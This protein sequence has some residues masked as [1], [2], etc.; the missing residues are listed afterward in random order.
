VETCQAAGIRPVMITGDH[1]LTARHI[2]SQLGIA[3]DERFLTG[4]ELDHLSTADLEKVIDEVSVYARVSPEHKLNLI[5]V[6]QNR[7]HIVAMTGD[8]VNDAPAL[9]KADIGVAMG[10]TGTD[11]TKEAADMV[12]QDDNF[13]TI[14]A[15]VE[16]GR[17][18]Y[19]NIRKFIKYL[20]SCNSGEIWAM[21]LAPLFGMPLPLLPLQILWMNLVTDGLPALALGVEPGERDT[22]RR[23]P[24]PPTEGIFSRGMARDIIWIGLIM[25]LVSLGVGYGYWQAGRANWQTMVFTV[26][27]LSQMSLALAV[28]SERDSFFSIGLLSNKAMLGAVS[29][30]LVLQLA[31]VYV[32]FL[33]AIFETTAL[34]GRDLV[35]GLALSSLVFWGVEF[36]KWLVRSK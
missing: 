6:F 15:A 36:K 16:E 8:G 27:T 24:Y 25:G 17:T 3:A 19:D 18:I 10:I 1:P 35:L 26:L 28:R 32:P 21:F 7:G 13:A 11:V 23:P 4:Q 9:K 22:M 33:Q 5:E 29:L 12:L 14:V 31:V 20:L 34:T 30:T 2:A